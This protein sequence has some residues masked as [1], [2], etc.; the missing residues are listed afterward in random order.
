VPVG[1]KIVHVPFR[2]GRP[3]GGYENFV[4]G[5][6]QPAGAERQPQMYGRPTALAVARDGSLLISDNVAGIVW[7]VAYT[8][9]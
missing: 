6:A 2:N 1:Y 4:T 8:G 5:F 9:K 7:R 3:A